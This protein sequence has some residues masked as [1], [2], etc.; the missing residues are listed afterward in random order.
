MT[1]NTL[2]S[3]TSPYLLQHAD[4][5]VHWQPWGEAAL[6]LARQQNKPILLSIGYSSCHWCHVMAEESFND[7]DTAGLMNRYFI[8]IK[9]D[10]EERPDLDRIYQQAHAMLT[11]RPG[12]WPLTVFLDPRDQMPFFAGTYFPDQPRHGLPAFR[13]LLDHIHQVWQTRQDDIARQSQSLREAMAKAAAPAATGAL[14][15]SDLLDICRNQIEQQFDSQH[16]G[17]SQPP[18]FPHPAIIGRALR[19]W[20]YSHAQQDDKAILHCA[21]YTLYRV[22]EGGVF[23][24]LGGG[25]FRYATDAQWMIP[26]FEKMLYDNGPLLSLCSQAWAVTADPRFHNAAVATADWVMREMQAEDGGYFTALDADGPQGEGDYYLWDRDE[27]LN[28]LEEDLR[29]RFRLRHGLD[30]SANFAGKWHLYGHRSEADIARE[31][32][33]DI[34]AVFS[35]LANARKQ[36]LKLRR[37]RPMPMRDEKIL[38]AW[39]GLMIAG[40]ATC[41][42]LLGQAHYIDSALRAARFL[43]AH[44]FDGKRLLAT[45]KDGKARFDAT[46]DDYAG[47]LTGLLALL[48]A[49]WDNSLYAWALQ[50]ADT[51]IEDFEDRE[52][53]GFFFTSHHHEALIQRPRVLHDEATPSGA[54][55][56][57][58]A[59]TRLGY[60]AGEQGY[61]D[62]VEHCLQGAGATIRQAPV[63]H[64]TLLTALQE[65]LSPPQIL[66]V[67]S[68]NDDRSRCDR[69]S[70]QKYLPDMLIFHLPAS[71]VPP[72]PL[73]SKVAMASSCA[74]P[75]TGFRCD[76]PLQGI[77]AIEQ[78][79]L[80][81]SYRAEE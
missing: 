28:A 66:I 24:H 45:F 46:L 70:Y 57:C 56:A 54:G 26:H 53:G 33:T 17:F 4:Q 75:C 25:F 16:G 44:C 12:G 60:L 65:T 31:T 43:H 73:D 69:L 81:K 35:Q 80:N 47:L 37:Q 49:K 3:E 19:H 62:S 22:I 71:E 79:V 50:L 21:I 55:L 51:L 13:Q 74:Y 9:V 78:H 59:L 61:L 7:R 10:R 32:D 68:Q 77:D 58:I 20:A 27:I 64:C 41:G 76:P 72:A 5:P 2:S 36:A 67:R 29:E 30:Q 18:K 39:N 15:G 23:D 42:R 63:A 14:P 34:A 40:M 52:N 1:H 38:T 48:Q 8:N 6:A 11:D